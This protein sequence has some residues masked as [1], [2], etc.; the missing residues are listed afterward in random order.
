MAPSM[1]A[2]T[3]PQSTVPGDEDAASPVGM[4]RGVLVGSRDRTVTSGDER[5]IQS[6][7]PGQP[8]SLNSWA[9]R[10]ITSAYG[11]RCVQ[12]ALLGRFTQ[13]DEVERPTVTKSAFLR[14]VS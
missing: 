5:C 10:M 6:G 8:R 7:C 13:V 9:M 14:P 2:T 12:L 3:M 4:D 1:Y 11:P